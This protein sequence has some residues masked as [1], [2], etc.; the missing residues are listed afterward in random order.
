MSARGWPADRRGWKQR[1]V[2]RPVRAEVSRTTDS[3]GVP[4]EGE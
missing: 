2:D 3:W 1:H 4:E